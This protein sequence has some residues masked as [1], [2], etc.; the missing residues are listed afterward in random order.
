M[1]SKLNTRSVPAPL[2]NQ[3]FDD[4]CRLCH[5]PAARIEARSFRLPRAH[6]SFQ[7]LLSLAKVL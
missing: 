7:L 3:V 5:A 4:T 2:I 1:P 6:D